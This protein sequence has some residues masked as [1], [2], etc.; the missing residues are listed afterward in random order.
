MGLSKALDGHTDVAGARRQGLAA[1]LLP[2]IILLMMAASPPGAL[3][4]TQPL[5]GGAPEA[6]FT[7]PDPADLS[8]EDAERTYQQIL[9]SMADAYDMSDLPAADGYWN[10]PRYNRVP[11]RSATHG[12]RFVN[13]Y[14]NEKAA[15]YSRYEEAGTLPEGA[16]LA[17]DSFAVTQ[18]GN[19]FTGPLFLMEKMASG[20]DPEARDWRYFM[21]MPDGSIF[22]ISKGEGDAKVRFCVECHEL[23]G[24]EL[25]HL[26]FVPEDFR[27]EAGGG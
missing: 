7:L 16:I 4:Q 9:P 21:I 14:A 20:F 12:E 19:V 18:S 26:F 25:D 13:N 10:W 3:A 5:K 24:D 2:A 23:T 17:K 22:G 15:A 1:S 11:Y 8:D 6:H 27:V